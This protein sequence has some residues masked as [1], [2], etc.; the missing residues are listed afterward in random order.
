[1]IAQPLTFRLWNCLCIACTLQA[2]LSLPENLNEELDRLR[3]VSNKLVED[4][5]KKQSGDAP[6]AG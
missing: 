5:S 2:D 1:M 3:D 4:L 6:R